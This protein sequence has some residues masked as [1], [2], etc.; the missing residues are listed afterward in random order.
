MLVGF[1]LDNLYCAHSYWSVYSGVGQT[2]FEYVVGMHRILCPCT[3]TV[4][5]CSTLMDTY[6]IRF[7]DSLTT[8]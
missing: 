6:K 1:P 8:S 4:V 3:F 5:K 7:S 2:S